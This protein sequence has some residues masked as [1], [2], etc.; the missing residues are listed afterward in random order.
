[1]YQPVDLDAIRKIRDAGS[2]YLSLLPNEI[3]QL[4]ID[5]FDNYDNKITFNTLKEIDKF[6]ANYIQNHAYDV[7][8]F[9]DSIIL[10]K[11]IIA[12][13]KGMHDLRLIYINEIKIYIHDDV[14]NC[15]EINTF[16]KSYVDNEIVG[17]LY[18]SVSMYGISYLSYLTFVET[19]VE[20]FLNTPST[21]I[22]LPCTIQR[23]YPAR[24][25]FAAIS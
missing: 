19:G 4:V 14:E 17:S 13:S 21:Y 11:P 5:C 2:T 15:H 6:I 23:V 1:M 20:S 9:N 8:A 24:Y 16:S 12:Y 7:F 10:H 25:N 18:S 3:F 22:K